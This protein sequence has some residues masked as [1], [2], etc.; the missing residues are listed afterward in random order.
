MKNAESAI[1]PNP[2]D[3]IARSGHERRFYPKEGLAVACYWPYAVHP[4]V[5]VK[6]K[7]GN[8]RVFG[9][10]KDP[11]AAVFSSYR[12][13]QASRVDRGSS[14]HHFLWHTERKHHHRG[15][16]R[17]F[18]NDHHSP[19]PEERF[20]R[21]LGSLLRQARGGAGRAEEGNGAQHENSRGGHVGLL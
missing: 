12:N 5:R 14:G 18:R 15:A 2:D 21:K 17:W 6:P 10:T 20:W 19:R 16:F 8:C 13:K 1:E 9:R 3:A 7:F 11:V 4:T